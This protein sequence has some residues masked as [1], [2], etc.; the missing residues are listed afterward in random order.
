MVLPY[1]SVGRLFE[2]DKE[3]QTDY[4]T[5]EFDIG[6]FEEYHTDCAKIM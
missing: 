2:I 4:V 3:A 1:A 6:A 5:E